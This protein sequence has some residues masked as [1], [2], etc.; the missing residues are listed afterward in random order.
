MFRKIPSKER[1]TN[2][3][4]ELKKEFSPQVKAVDS[5]A[6]GILDRYSKVIFCAMILLIVAS[7]I[8]TFFVIKPEERTQS[9]IFE[10]E[11]NAIPEGLGSEFSA[12]QNLSSRAVKMAELKTEIER[13]IS[14]ESMSKEDSAYLEKAIEQLQYFNTK[15]KE[16]EH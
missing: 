6:K 15:S 3:F 7:F 14:Q 8:L 5:L 4:R 11:L 16:D 13:I 9:G 2:V 12:L 10:D 1:N